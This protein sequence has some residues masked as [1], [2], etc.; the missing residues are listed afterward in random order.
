MEREQHDKLKI[1]Q[2][3]GRHL[4]FLTGALSTPRAVPIPSLSPHCCHST[5]ILP[6]HLLKC[7]LHGHLEVEGTEIQIKTK[8][9]HQPCAD[10]RLAQMKQLLSDPPAQALGREGALGLEH[11]SLHWQVTSHSASCATR[12]E[13]VIAGTCT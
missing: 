2:S 3:P 11:L 9:A 6:L 7:M 13:V 5:F 10:G 1:L 8:L 12:G 4:T